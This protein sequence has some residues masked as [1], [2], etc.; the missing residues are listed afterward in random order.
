MIQ[1]EGDRLQI[2]VPMVMSTANGLLEAGRAFF[3][4]SHRQVDLSLVEQAD[5][6]GL[7]VLLEWQRLSQAAGGSVQL[8]EM[9]EG[10]AA[11]ADLYDLSEVFTQA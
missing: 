5:S 1:C 4:G 2:K 10:L 7:A 3:D 11:L 6:A 8:L 9:P